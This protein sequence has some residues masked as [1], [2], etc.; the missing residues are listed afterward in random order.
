MAKQK[1]ILIVGGPRA[2]TNGI[3]RFL[4]RLGAAEPR[5]RPTANSFGQDWA[6]DGDT[7]DA[8]TRFLGLSRRFFVNTVRPETPDSKYAERL[9]AA[10]RAGAVHA[11]PKPY[12]LCSV[13]VA[14]CLP[15]LFAA[16]PPATHDYFAVRLTRPKAARVASYKTA[17]EGEGVTVTVQEV[18]SYIDAC[19][20]GT[21]ALVAEFQARGFPVRTVSVTTLQGVGKSVALATVAGALGLREP[22]KEDLDFIDAGK[23]SQ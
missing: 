21:D 10:Y 7:E 15:E 2:V 1:I 11:A 14:L 19:D 22:Q 20:V 3:G 5:C 6:I 9:V 23:L 8:A 18:T 16:L 4:H 13:T 17:C 12:L